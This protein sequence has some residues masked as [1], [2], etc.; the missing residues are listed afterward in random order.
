MISVVVFSGRAKALIKSPQM[1]KGK[2]LKRKAKK[3]I[4]RNGEGTEQS[5]V[6]LQAV[7]QEAVRKYSNLSEIE[8][9]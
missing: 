9:H 4:R 5:V 8:V 1:L 6:D 2:R 3:M 7:G